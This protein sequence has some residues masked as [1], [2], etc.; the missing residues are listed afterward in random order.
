MA[1]NNDLVVTAG[2]NIEASTEQIKTEL[3]DIGKDLSDKKALKITCHIDSA[4]V[5][6]MQTELSK[7]TKN[8]AKAF[9]DAFNLKLPRGQTAEVRKEIQEL[10]NEYKKFS[11][12]NDST[13]KENT[14]KALVQYM[15]QFERET[16]IVNEELESQ[17]RIINELAKKKGQ[18]VDVSAIYG[19]LEYSVGKKNADKSLTSLFGGRNR[20]TL[21]SGKGTI[22]FDQLIAEINN[23]LNPDIFKNGGFFGE[24]KFAMSAEGVAQILHVLTE[25]SNELNEAWDKTFGQEQYNAHL[26]DVRN[27]LNEIVGSEKEVVNE[28]HKVSEDDDFLFDMEELDFTEKK[29]EEIKNDV[30]EIVDTERSLPSVG[31]GIDTK[32]TLEDAKTVLN[33]FFQENKIDGEATRIKR[34]VEDTT[35]ELKRFY[36]QVERGDKS[37]ETLTYALNEQGD[38][39]EY[40]GKTIREADN[41]TDFRRKGLDVQKQLQTENLAKFEAQ[42]EKSGVATDSLKERI[43]LLWDAISKIDDT[44]GMNAFLDDLDI[45]KAQFQALNAEAQKENFAISLSNKIKKLSA[46]MNAYA[47]ANE[48][49]VKSTK[50][51]SDG[52]TFMAKWSDLTTKMAKGADLGSAGI[53]HL[54]EEFRIFAKEAEAAGL[55]GESAW[56]KFLNSFKTMSSYITANMVFNFAKRQLRDMVNEVTAVDTA[57]TELRKVAEATNAEFEAFAKSAGQTGRELGAS[58]SDVINATSTFS[59]AGFNL[60]DAEELGKIATLYKNVGDGITIDSASESIIS[61]MKAFNIEAENSI[62]I[63]DRINEVSNR[64]AIDSGGLGLA[65]QRVASAMRA[66]NNSLD[67]TIALTTVSNEIVQNPEMVSQGWRTVA[68]RI[69]GAK[70][71]LEDAGLETEGMVESTAKLRDLIKGISGVDIMLDENTFKSTYQ[72]IDELGRVWDKISDIDQ[73]SLLEAIAGRFYLNVQKCA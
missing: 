32:S 45:A 18:V 66:A 70:S 36:V 65:L 16:Y 61:V 59:R 57:M 26:D 42:V 23:S 46:D 47:V 22:D 44:N 54:L 68:L 39:Y 33:D 50:Q 27:K 9:T 60:P 4:S 73:A 67:E 15:S 56:G 21:D 6:S 55:K 69:R 58:I 24:G 7:A 35:G 31:A 20:W 52:T 30:R 49:A 5:R 63:I 51:M 29:I 71:E 62:G 1:K 13:G 53:K 40:L 10:I 64:A 43:A 28:A 37:I 34:A 8:Q 11:D 19:D 14:F 3:G 41:S 25:E 38:A 48:R 72:I 12:L 17:K 2:L